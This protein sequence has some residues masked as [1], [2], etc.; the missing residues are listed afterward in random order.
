M[1]TCV[2]LLTLLGALSI[3]PN[4][5]STDQSV[6][7]TIHDRD[8]RNFCRAVVTGN[9]TWCEFIQDKR[10]KELCRVKSR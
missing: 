6:C 7:Q 5:K 9:K 3:E 8:D 4:R 1:W 10:T 2:A